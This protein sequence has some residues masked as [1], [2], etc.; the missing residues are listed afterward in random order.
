LNGVI[1]LVA[2]NSLLSIVPIMALLWWAWFKNNDQGQSR[3]KVV[4][5]TIIGCI[6]VGIIFFFL[7]ETQLIFEYRSNPICSQA[8][9]FQIPDGINLN[10]QELCRNAHTSFPSGHAALLFALS[11]GIAYISRITGVLCMFYSIVICLARIF[12]GLHYP[13]D[14]IGG[15]SLGVGIVYLF[16]LSF[17]RNLLIQPVLKWSN[18][19][20]PSFYAVS[21]VISC[22]IA[23]YCSNSGDIIRF[24]LKILNVFLS[25][26]S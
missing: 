10:I 3:R 19:H 2:N 17:I 20:S 25:F 4:V 23:T 6:F 7:R 22:E 21:F 24:F 18:Y 14:I 15:A 1:N 8:I 12:L 16:N 9:N 26:F 11:F 5:A 13:T